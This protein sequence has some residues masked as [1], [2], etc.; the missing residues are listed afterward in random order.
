MASK[1][2]LVKLPRVVVQFLPNIMP[3][4]NTHH[5]QQFLGHRDNFSVSVDK[6]K[7]HQHRTIA[8]CHLARDIMGLP[9]LFSQ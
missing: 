4:I 3:L 8:S 1:V 2:V 6:D 7:E 5:Q 9:I